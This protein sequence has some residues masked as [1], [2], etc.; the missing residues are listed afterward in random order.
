M[1]PVLGFEEFYSGV[2]LPE[3]QDARCRGLHYVGTATALAF[4]AARP[5]TFLSSAAAVGAGLAVRRP[6]E[7]Q[8]SGLPEFAVLLAVFLGLQWRLLGSLPLAA[9]PLGAGYGCAWVGHFFLERNR[10]ATFVHPTLSLMGDFRML[11]DAARGA[12]WPRGGAPL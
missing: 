9:A 1:P 10:P 7:S 3:H 11:Y 5:A 4:A 6:L 2:Y 8:R 12:L